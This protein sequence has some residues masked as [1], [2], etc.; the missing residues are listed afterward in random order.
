[1]IV[2]EP[3]ILTPPHDG[4]SLDAEDVF[5]VAELYAKRY[6]GCTFVADPEAGGEQLC[7]RIE[8]E[9]DTGNVYEFSQKTGPMCGASQRLAED[10]AAGKLRHPDHD[11]LNRH[12]LAA[13]AKFVGPMWRLV[14]PKGKGAVID[15]AIALAMANDMLASLPPRRRSV[16]ESQRLMTV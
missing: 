9:L 3:T 12:V 15:A 13:A 10:I 5:A 14:K 6:P 4:T 11:E 7:Q 8:R 16:Y 2:G 1:V